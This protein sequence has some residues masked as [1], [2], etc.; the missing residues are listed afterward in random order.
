MAIVV[1]MVPEVLFLSCKKYIP[2][3]LCVRDMYIFVIGHYGAVYRD[4]V[5]LFMVT[6]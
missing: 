3:Q 4:S 6:I 5:E 1:H 2:G